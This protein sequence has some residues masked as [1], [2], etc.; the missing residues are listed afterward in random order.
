[1]FHP[2]NGVQTTNRFFRFSASLDTIRSFKIK[3]S[4]LST[5]SILATFQGAAIIENQIYEC[6]LVEVSNFHDPSQLIDIHTISHSRV[7]PRVSGHPS[8]RGSRMEIC[9]SSIKIKPRGRHSRIGAPRI[10]FVSLLN[11]YLCLK[12]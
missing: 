7:E 4:N 12:T 6:V 3:I 11:I 9:Y 8:Y 1:M 2:R 5:C 10:E